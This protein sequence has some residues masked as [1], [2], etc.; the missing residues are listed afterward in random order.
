MRMKRSSLLLVFLLPALAAICPSADAQPGTRLSTPAWTEFRVVARRYDSLQA[1]FKTM[2]EE[3]PE[4]KRN[5]LLMQSRLQ[6]GLQEITAIY[7]AVPAKAQAAMTSVQGLDGYGLEDLRLIKLAAI[8]LNDIPKAQGA[9]ERLA[10]L[11]RD[12]DS[13]RQVKRELAQLS[14]L[15]GELDK[16]AALATDENLSDASEMEKA[17]L[18]G[19][20]ATG[21]ADD[22]RLE[23]A[24]DYAAR[25]VKAL[26]SYQLQDL[27]APGMPVDSMQRAELKKMQDYYFTSQ[28]ADVVGSVAWLCKSTGGTAAKDAFLAS[29]RG[30]VGD[31]ALW[32]QTSSGLDAN[33]QK[34]DGERKTLNQPAPA[35]APHEWI[36]TPPLALEGLAG[37]V[38]LVDFFA[39]WCKPCIMAFPHLREWTERYAAQG[40]VV[41]GLTNAQGRYDGKTLGADEEFAK[42]KDDFIPKH[43]LT[44]AIG[45]E[46]SGRKTF[47]DYGVNGIPHVVLIDR[48]GVLRYL[49]VGAA[50]YDKTEK[51][52]KKLLAE[53]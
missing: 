25:T 10:A 7:Q 20:I 31:S 17:Q 22:G 47:T 1:V 19:S 30:L 16:A 40:L 46:K 6:N 49:K 38:V 35:W 39:T 32:A 2:Q 43:K 37:K 9:N 23:Q 11:L 41:V 26:R 4:L 24:K 51:M 44:W 21:A 27:N 36:G 14:A 5:P 28:L 3:H 42:V 15:Q 45:V 50:D 8:S 13:I 34:L 29:M 48:K 53:K 33:I 18:Y 12:P 52:I